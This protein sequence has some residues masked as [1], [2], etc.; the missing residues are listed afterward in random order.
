MNKRFLIISISG[1]LILAILGGLLFL[2]VQKQ[3]QSQTASTG[4][5]LQ[6]KKIS[7]ENILSAV[8]SLDGSAVW[9]FNSSGRLFRINPDGAGLV[10]FP[11]PAFGGNLL[12][13][14]WPTTGSDFLAVGSNNNVTFK[15]FYDS[16]NKLYINLPANVKNID[17]MPDGKRVVYIWKSSDNLH[18][19]LVV[20]NADGTGFRTV[21]DVFWSDLIPKV[22]PDGT[23]VLLYRYSMI[24][25]VN[26]IYVIDLN[27]GEISN[28]VEEGKNSS[29]VWLSD[30]QR[31]IYSQN[32]A[33]VYPKLYLYDFATKTS[34]DLNLSTNINKILV[35][36]SDKFLY[37][38]V[39]KTDNSGDNFI[40]LDLA[41]LKQESYY[42]PSGQIRGMNLMLLGNTLYFVN[43]V[44]GKLYSLE[45]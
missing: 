14:Q 8:P 36:G 30:S 34:T 44:D 3:K 21:K 23:K 24:G 26:K 22:S 5:T 20:A 15:S 18:Q 25:D 42:E 6:T 2:A 1:F 31:F 39:P 12:T 13:V 33:S 27:T 9:Y 7:D 37:A 40:K 43:S 28:V 16:A 4:A 38:A 29:A 32:S 35:D 41:T 19:S 45:K 11:L 17:W 10:E